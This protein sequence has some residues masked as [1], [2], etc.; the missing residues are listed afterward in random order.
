MWVEAA[1]K[2]R[3]LVLSTGIV[4]SR[5]EPKIGK[6][7]QEL[8]A[9]TKY[10]YLVG[11]K[12]KDYFWLPGVYSDWYN[13]ETSETRRTFAIGITKANNVMRQVHNSRLRMPCVFTD[14][15]AW[16]W[17]MG[18]LSDER[19][20]ELAMT[21]IPSSMLEVCTIDPTYRTTGEL[22]EKEYPELKAIDLTFL[23]QEELEFNYWKA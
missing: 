7:G 1:R 21:Q 18:D 9:T 22:L 17:L 5:H 12:E 16:E 6:K 4:E 20:T 14:D 3:C 15:L 2:R 11:V 23:D 13:P 10:P 8:K 19:I